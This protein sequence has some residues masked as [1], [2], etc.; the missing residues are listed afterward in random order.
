MTAISPR[1]SVAGVVDPGLPASATPATEPH[2]P[3][4]GFTLTEMIVVIAIIVLLIGIAIPAVRGLTGD[5][6]TGAAYNELSAIIGQARQDAMAL[7]TIHGVVFYLDPATD[8]IDA[9]Y[10]QS[11]TPPSGYS[12]PQVWL[13]TVPL[14]EQMALPNGVGLQTIANPSVT[15]NT[16]GSDR[17]LGFNPS[18]TSIKFGGVILFDANG[19][20]VTQTYCLLCNTIFGGGAVTNNALQGGPPLPNTTVNGSHAYFPQSQFG[21]VLFDRDA[22][23]NQGFPDGDYGLDQSVTSYNAAKDTWLDANS[24]PV[25]VNRYNGTLIKG[26]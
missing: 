7:Q 24:T 23:L 20:L 19:R 16:P 22:F 5:R 11:V 15:G 21:F 6:N 14:R 3:R 25:L 18:S 26:E 12:T 1:S 4:R 17:Y 9:M 2:R 13:D 8:R 10:V